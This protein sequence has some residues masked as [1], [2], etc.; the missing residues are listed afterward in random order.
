MQQPQVAPLIGEVLQAVNNQRQYAWYQEAGQFLVGLAAGAGALLT[1]TGEAVVPVAQVL[2]AGTGTAPPA[3]ENVAPLATENA[4]KVTAS[5]QR[6]PTPLGKWGQAR[7][8][9]AL[10]SAGTKPTVPLTTSL[11]HAMWVDLRAIGHTRQ[12][13]GST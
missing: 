1:E 7:L 5:V 12:R 6:G 11:G 2:D 8:P 3:V 4:G 10:N 9:Q 13:P